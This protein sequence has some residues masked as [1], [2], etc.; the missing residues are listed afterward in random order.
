MSAC[1]SSPSFVSKIS[2]SASL[3]NLPTGNT[4]SCTTTK[5]MIVLLYLSS[6]L[7]TKSTGLCRRMYLICCA[8]RGLLFTMILSF[9]ASAAAPMLATVPFTVTLPSRIKSSAARRLQTPARAMI[10]CTRS[11]MTLVRA[12]MLIKRVLFCKTMIDIVVPQQNE[13]ELAV[14]AELLG[15]THVIALYSSKPSVVPVTKISWIP[16][17]LCD[18]KVFL[19]G[20]R[21]GCF[22][23]RSSDVDRAVLE[24]GVFLMFGFEHGVQKD[25]LNFRMS[26]LNHVM[27]ALAVAKKT[28]IAFSLT[29]MLATAG[30]A[31]SCLFGRIAQNI[32]LCQKYNVNVLFGSFAKTPLEMRNPRDMEA[33]FTLL[34]GDVKQ[35]VE[36]V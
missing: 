6:L 9:S 13:Q 19:K 17:V 15:Y 26:G 35:L 11:S 30:S 5:D 33:L 18:A 14:M 25:R 31:R 28:M 20:K 2:P 24:R 1:A 32:H 34:G 16:V 27:C 22:A 23:V 3:S 8:S 36:R 10:F 21:A 4:R 7:V 29:D 12:D